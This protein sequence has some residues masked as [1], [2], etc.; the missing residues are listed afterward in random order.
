MRDDGGGMAIAMSAAAAIVAVLSV[1][2]ASIGMLYAARAQAETAADAAALAAAVSSYPPAEPAEPVENA[3]SAARA[4][5]AILEVCRCPRDWS[6]EPRTVEVVA[7]IRVHVPIFGE[8]V[9]R[10][11]ARAE[12]APRDWLGS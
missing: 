8:V 1:A 10:S 12:F 7:A 5:G 3:R 6:L 11:P 4:N 9:V 2:V